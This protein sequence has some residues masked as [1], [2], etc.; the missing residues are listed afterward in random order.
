MMF[1]KRHYQWIY[2]DFST[3]IKILNAKR[4]FRD[5][6]GANMDGGDVS[7]GEEM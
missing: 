1:D 2:N 6:Y 5:G 3:Q 7:A 4:D